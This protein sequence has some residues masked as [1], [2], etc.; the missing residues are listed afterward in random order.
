MAKDM[1]DELVMLDT[2]RYC[3]VC[4]S[5]EVEYGEANFENDSVYIT[6]TCNT[7]KSR[8]TFTYWVDGALIDHDGRR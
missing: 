6:S 4:G 2:D 1:T 3:P 8:F 7:C 5:R